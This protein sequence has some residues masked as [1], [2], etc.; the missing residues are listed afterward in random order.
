MPRYDYRC[1]TCGQVEETVHGFDE[2]PDMF[3]LEC[4]TPML[5]LVSG[6]NVAPSATPS[7]STTID[8]AATRQAERAK[9]ADMAAY[10]RLR[11]DGLQPPTINGSSKLE[12]VAET[13]H[14]VNSGHVFSNNASR[15]RSVG[16]LDDMASE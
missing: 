12:H 13:S 1:A 9:D 6:V 11:A 7:R 10:R 2:T 16:L 4:G 5:K 14:E 15:R 3:C 8:L